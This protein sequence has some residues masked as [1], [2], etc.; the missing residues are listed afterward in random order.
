MRTSIE[1]KEV[2]GK[3]N[4]QNTFGGDLWCTKLRELVFG[5]LIC[6]HS[7]QVRAA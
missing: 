2:S 6:V 4:N 7:I 3:H 5:K 1:R